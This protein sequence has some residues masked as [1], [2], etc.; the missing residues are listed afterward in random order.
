IAIFDLLSRGNPQQQQSGANDARASKASSGGGAETSTSPE[1]LFAIF[2]SQCQLNL[3]VVLLFSPS[4]DTLR[5]RIQLFPALV[6]CCTIDWYTTWALPSLQAV[7]QQELRT[8]FLNP[9]KYLSSLDTSFPSSS[10]EQE[11][12]ERKEEDEGLQEDSEKRGETVREKDLLEREEEEEEEEEEESKEGE[13][14]KI[15]GDSK[16]ERNKKKKKKRRKG[17]LGGKMRDVLCH[18]F[19]E[20][21]EDVTKITEKFRLETKRY[22]YVTPASYVEFLKLFIHLNSV[23]SSEIQRQMSQYKSGLEKINSTSKQVAKIQ[24]ELE[25][26]KPQ[27]IQSTQETNDLMENISRIQQNAAASKAVIEREE[28]ICMRQAKEASDVKEQCQ[29]ELDIAMPALAS[30]IEALQK[31]SKSD[32]TELNSMKAPPSGVIKVMEALC[33]MF[34]IHPVKAKSSDNSF[35]KTDDYWTASKK[36]LLNDSRFLQRLFTYDKDHIPTDIMNEILPY[37]TDP[38]FN[39]EVIKKASV[40]AT[41]LC[42]WVLAIILYDQ[43]VKVVGPKQRALEKAEKELRL[44]MEK[45]NEK[46]NELRDVESL[47]GQLMQQ[48]Q[49]AEVK[50][51]DLTI[52]YEDCLRRL[53]VAERLIH[54]LAGENTRWEI[55]YSQLQER[56]KTLLGEIILTSAIAAYAGVFTAS[57]RHQCLG[58]WMETLS[59]NGVKLSRAFDLQKAAG[60]SLQ[61]QNWVY[62]F[63]P[64]D[65]LSIENALILTLSKKRWPMLIDPQKQAIRWLKKTYPD[66]TVLRS[67][68]SGDESYFFSLKVAIEIGS[69]VLLENCGEELDASLDPLLARAVFK[70]GGSVAMIRLKD[71]TIEYSRDFQLYLSTLLPN[72]HFSPEYCSLLTII[73]F[74]VTVEGLEDQLLN[75]LV[76]LEKPAIEARRHALILESSTSQQQLKALE[77]KILSLLS[78]AKGDILDDKELIATLGSSK[79]A[80]QSIEERVEEQKKTEELIERTRK[81]YRSVA[82]RSARFFVVVT[83]LAEIDG[84]YQFSV[85]WFHDIFIQAIQVGKRKKGGEE[86]EGDF[87]GHLEEI[88]REFLYLLYN[89]ICR[90]IFESHKLLFSILL[91]L[92]SLAIDN[93]LDSSQLQ[94]LLL[95]G[96][97][98]PSSSSS[99]SSSSSCWYE[100]PS[101]LVDHPWLSHTAWER[102]VGLDETLRD[103]AFLD[104]DFHEFFVD[105]IDEWKVVFDEDDPTTLEWPDDIDQSLTEL[106]RC[107][108]IQAIRPDCLVRCLRILVEEKLGHSFLDPPAFDL[109][110]SFKLATPTRPL[111]F[112]L[113]SGADPM[114]CLLQLA[115]KHRMER[116]LLSISLGQGQGPK[117]VSAIENAVETGAWVLLQNCHLGKSFLSQLE[118]IVEDFA[119]RKSIHPN[120]R[121][122]L[123]SMPSP[124]FPVSIL[125]N[126]VKVTNEPPR[127]L[128]QNLLQSY[129]GFD[130]KFLEEHA[131]PK[132]W[133]NMLFGLCYFHALLLERRKFG[134]LGWNVY[135]E[136]SQS[137]ISISIQQLKQ[138]LEEYEE[139][140][141]KTLK[142]LIAETNYGGR[143]TDPWDRRLINYIIDDI[144]SPGILEENFEL[145]AIEPISIPSSDSTLEDY[146]SFI[147]NTLPTDEN[148]EVY[149]LHPNASMAVSLAE[150]NFI[151]EKLLSL[152]PPLTEGGTEK[153]K[154]K[155]EEGEEREEEE[156]SEGDGEERKKRKNRKGRREEGE[157]EGGEEE[158]EKGKEASSISSSSQIA[159]SIAQ[160]I[161]DQ[162]P[163]P[164]DVAAVQQKYPVRYEDVLNT[165]LVQELSRFNRLLHVIFSNLKSLQDAIKG[166]ILLTSELEETAKS[167]VENRVPVCFARVSYPSLKPLSSWIKD[168]LQRLSFFQ[169]WIDHGHPSTFWLSGFFFTQSFLTGILQS[170]ARKEK[171]P[172]DEISFDFAVLPNSA[173]GAA[174]SMLEPPSDGGEGGESIDAS[175]SSLSGMKESGRK[176]GKSGC[177]IYGL[178]MDGARWDSDEQVIAESLPKIL[179]AEMPPILLDP[180]P[181]TR[182]KKAS[183]A[184]NC[185]V[186]KTAVRAGTLSTT[187]HSTNYVLT[188]RLAISPEHTEQYWTKRG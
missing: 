99:S 118:R 11:E 141:W 94:L 119:L 112:I 58:A 102:I 87:T 135:Y 154:E 181:S 157:Q 40:A 161:L 164:F 68:T 103:N 130:A 110:F 97:S 125:L 146:L 111:I 106:E 59:H 166:L 23:K 95:G 124:D 4:G 46:K 62:N 138:F 44:A 54:D 88:N 171:I 150:A 145:S 19:A 13:E 78:N 120:F 14:R 107:L 129:L 175:S 83:N 67:S 90:S 168:L 9:P 76:S 24:S 143:I 186:Y 56:V 178:Y 22:N 10:G 29:R 43:A 12:E 172:V 165:V 47:I 3:H 105:Y 113:S 77:E 34:K 65:S 71:S 91:A 114:N 188:I 158:G 49:E 80:S 173:T 151:L 15:D 1:D 51:Q 61:I 26:L 60:D 123:T 104:Q 53:E 21:Q 142:Y 7:A 2:V 36:H 182:P 69:T 52:Q 155:E 144:Y 42:K 74:S 128:R 50:K 177:C 185:P 167:L 160:S 116:Q 48:H 82:H 30:A 5:K 86:E 162:L 132:I 115:K 17:S 117:A 79:G 180:G 41:S 93:E 45:L 27:I 108:V 174:A 31:L 122:F 163:K 159:A 39:P 64:N 170:Y 153:D 81:D 84:M 100:K 149:T 169:R 156:D 147:R 85:E 101:E 184:Y 136:F 133:R 176:E 140:P 98:L 109:H 187:G 16:K 25:I 18:I 73:N 137:D 134:P 57:Y 70:A 33:K 131:K 92:T 126:S 152:Q 179:F 89:S 6:N 55:S 72:P 28:E 148:P 96:G 32:I 37:Q 75:I 139:V 20:M 8:F 121:L 127:G 38:D 35:K 63:L 66:M 183:H